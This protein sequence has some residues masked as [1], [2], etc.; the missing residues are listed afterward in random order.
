M[1]LH[2]AGKKALV[3]GGTRGIGRAI[4]L[5][6][7]AQG[8]SVAACYQQESEA[9]SSLKEELKRYDTESY[10]FQADVSSKEDIEHLSK[11]VRQNFGQLNILVN[12]AGVISH[13]PLAAM[14]LEQWQQVI[15]T[16]LTSLYLVIHATQDLLVEGGSIINIGS[17][18]A[19]VGVPAR[20]HYTAAK[21]GVIGFSRSLCK[22]LGP[23]GIRVNVIAPGIIDTR[24][25]EGLS[26][27]Q[28]AR[29]ASMAAL[30]R[31]GHPDDIANVALFLSS[32][33]SRFVSG[34]TI[35]MDGGI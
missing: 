25:A 13:I 26:K 19:A 27:E 20:V 23:R 33:L 14:E 31:L 7:A 8:V 35:N 1:D 32:D 4:V 2:L 22:E 18:V 29:Y 5:A 12:N 15:N 28:R 11:S 21:A 10:V 9:V 24:Q 17:A 34:T 16:N 6:L 3:T 30:G